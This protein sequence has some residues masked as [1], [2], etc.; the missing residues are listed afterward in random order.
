MG[1]NWYVYSNLRF[2]ANY[3]YS[4][5]NNAPYYAD[6]DPDPNVEDLQLFRAN[7]DAH[8]FQMRAQVDF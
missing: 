4:D 2:M 1:L 3:I 5:I 7:G 8:I 6:V